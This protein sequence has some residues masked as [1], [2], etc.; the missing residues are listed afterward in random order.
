L[1][2]APITV[3]GTGRQTR[4]LCYVDDTVDA[5]LRLAKSDTAG[6]VNIGNPAELT[7]LEIAQLIRDLTVSDSPIE[8][9]PAMED[10]PQRRCPD[11][12]VAREQLGWEPRV[13]HDEGLTRTVEWFRRHRR[14]TCASSA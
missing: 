4:S 5:L 10:D 3:N 8:H 13:P 11:I 1:D 7:V 9:R 14:K 12:E 6:P 2:G